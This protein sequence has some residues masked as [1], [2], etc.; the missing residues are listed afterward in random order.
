[1]D[2]LKLANLVLGVQKEYPAIEVAENITT[3]QHWNRRT[4]VDEATDNRNAFVVIVFGNRVNQTGGELQDLRRSR[5]RVLD[6]LDQRK[7]IP[8]SGVAGGD[9]IHFFNVVLSNVSCIKFSGQPIE[10][11]AKGIA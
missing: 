3:L 6:R 2:D 11:E 1:M 7:T 4:V 9:E 5:S 10:R 8:P